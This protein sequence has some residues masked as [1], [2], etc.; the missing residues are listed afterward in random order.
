MTFA[1]GLLVSDGYYIVSEYLK[2]SFIGLIFLLYY[3]VYKLPIKS[4]TLIMFFFICGMGIF[5]CILS[6]SA[7]NLRYFLSQVALILAC[8]SLHQIS[9]RD[10]QGIQKIERFAKIFIVSSIVNYTGLL[11]FSVDVVHNFMNIFSTASTSRYALETVGGIR[12]ER[13]YFLSSEPSTHAITVF[14]LFLVLDRNKRITT[15]WKLLFFYS[16]LATFSL[17]GLILFILYYAY[18]KKMYFPIY[19]LGGL[20]SAWTFQSAEFSTVNKLL[21]T[22]SDN[23]IQQFSY[24]ASMI[25]Y[26]PTNIDVTKSLDNP[27]LSLWLL[28]LIGNGYLIGAIL[29]FFILIPKNHLFNKICF[30]I[31]FTVL[32]ISY[33]LAASILWWREKDET[34][35]TL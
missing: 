18:Y 17:S 21:N 11:V 8:Y 28:I 29:L 4:V 7:I 6:G 2:V 31:I 27:V 15:F 26:I 10:L 1:L 35:H 25:N 34:S 23:R 3:S 16:A 24:T 12:V 5:G 22:A 19:V 30:V 13:L 9:K 14:T 33:F 32:P 20:L